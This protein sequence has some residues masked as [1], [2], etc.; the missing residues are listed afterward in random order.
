M[1]GNRTHPEHAC[2]A[3]NNKS[4]LTTTLLLQETNTCEIHKVF[5][6]NSVPEVVLTAQRAR[7]RSEPDSSV[8]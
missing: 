2:A 8:V 7:L 6:V 3:I 4:I 5:L 1:A